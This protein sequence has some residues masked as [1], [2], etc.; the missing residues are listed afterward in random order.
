MTVLPVTQID[1]S[2]IPSRSR[3]ARASAVGAK[4]SSAR[5]VARA[6]FFSSGNGR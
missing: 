5:C 4:W 2:A 6:R 3:F 1:E